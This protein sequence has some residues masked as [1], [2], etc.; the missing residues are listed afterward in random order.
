M[1]KDPKDMSMEE[2]A[3]THR[4]VGD[5]FWPLNDEINNRCDES[6]DRWEREHPNG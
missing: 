6:M 2:L 1:A 5:K 4:E 3:Q